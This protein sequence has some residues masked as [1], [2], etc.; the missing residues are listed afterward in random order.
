MKLTFLM[1]MIACLNVSA[2]VF[3]QEKLSFDI[4]NLKLSRALQMIEKQSSFRFV[5]SPTEGP[6]NK[7]ISVKVKKAPITEVLD[8]LLAGTALVYTIE[9]NNLI[10][11][12]SGVRVV[13]DITVT[14]VVTDT[15]GVPLPG[16]SVSVKGI[17]GLGGMTDGDG[18]FTLKVPDNSILVF[19]FISFQTREVQASAAG[20]MRIVL[21]ESDNNLDEV[22][23]Q[24]YGTTT[25]RKT[26]SAISTLD[27][28]NVAQLPVQSIN[29]AVAGRVPGVIVTASNGGPGSKSSISIRGGLTPLFVIDGVIRSANDFSNLNPNDIE[30]YSVL[31]DAAATAL[32]GVSA[33]NGVVVVTT[34]KGREG[35]TSINY[36]YN[37]IFSKPTLFPEK[38][39]SFDQLSALNRLYADEGKGVFVQPAD[40]EKYRNGSDPFNFPNTD[41]QALT[42]KNYAPEM[43]HD[44][45]ITS[46]NKLL[47]YYAAISHYDQGTILKTDNNYNKRTTY[48]LNTVSNFDNV[49]LKVTAGIDGFIEKNTVP[50]VGYYGVYSHIQNSSTRQIAL[51]EYGLPSTKPDNPVRELDA[52]S[53]Y[54]RNLAKVLNTNLGLEYSAPF[55]KG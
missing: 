36:S 55:W 39:S 24:A 9:Q 54:D 1:V 5:Y 25:R 15:A 29:D 17:K 53:G 37:Q 28:K 19:S 30:D 27:M 4:E 46:G 22:V 14:G 50:Y 16:V 38:V 26:T 40:L 11:I 47:T 6:F 23:V 21:K 42:M 3:S 43:R 13:K 8:Q 35:A 34:K 51:N 10:T 2:N 31:K 33:A 7:Q 52:K 44:L 32:Y 18:K 49:H 20:V 48:R 45:S 41:W 12:S